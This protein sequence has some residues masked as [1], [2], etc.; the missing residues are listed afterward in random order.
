MRF[1]RA[2]KLAFRKLHCA[3]QDGT[4]EGICLGTTVF[5][6]A[7]MRLVG[8]EKC[9]FVISSTVRLWGL[10][11]TGSLAVV[12]GLAGSGTESHGSLWA[13][14]TGS[15]LA[16]DRA[17]V[18][19]ICG[20]WKHCLHRA[21]S[22]ARRPSAFSEPWQTHL[23]WERC[24]SLGTCSIAF[25]VAE[26]P[27]PRRFLCPPSPPLPS[28]PLHSF[29]LP[30]LSITMS[31][32][33]RHHEHHVAH[34]A[35]GG[36]FAGLK[37][38]KAFAKRVL[39]HLSR[40]RASCRGAFRGARKT[41]RP[42]A[43]FRGARKTHRTPSRYGSTRSR[44]QGLQARKTHVCRGAFGCAKNAPAPFALWFHPEQV[45]GL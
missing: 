35:Q 9:I 24:V 26:I 40:I 10:G 3:I 8:A 33:A 29:T 1:Y 21:F 34:V 36:R 27:P 7:E 18:R 20:F 12:S 25:C 45:Q 2:L 17:R 11:T 16:V 30:K 15:R 44:V 41:H 43:A 22:L 28:P 23:L 19:R 39:G 37:T 5:W 14:A 4:F 32:G 42:R 31:T 13:L 38:Q 6:G